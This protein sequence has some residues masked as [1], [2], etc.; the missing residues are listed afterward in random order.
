V[1]AAYAKNNPQSPLALYALQRYA[2]Y[3]NQEKAEPIF[4]LLPK[5]A[6]ESLAGTTLKNKME[7]SKKQVSA[8]ML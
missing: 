5:S 2:G 1:Y 4:N 6:Q 3:E 8:N 7:V